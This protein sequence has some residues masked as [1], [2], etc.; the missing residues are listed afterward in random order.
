MPVLADIVARKRQDVAAR[1]A[2]TPLAVLEKQA[3]PTTRRLADALRRPGLRFIL[4]CKKASPS[5]GLIRPDFDVKKIAETYRGFADAVSV[6]T[7][8]PYF[9]GSFADLETVRA[10]LSQPILCKDFVV[11]PYQVFEAR[12][13]GADAVLLMLSVLDDA[14]YRRCAEAARALSMDVLTEV[15]DD[16]ELNRAL[17]LDARIVG[18]NNRDLKT[19]KINLSTTRHLAPKI[20]RDRVIVSESGIKSRADIDAMS[21]FVDAF[22]VGS[23]LMKDARLDSAVR[24][25]IFG[26][27]KIC[28]LT[29]PDAARIAYEAGASWGGLIFAPES[30]RCVS[31][32]SAR[33]IAEAS[34]LPMVGVFV[35][36]APEKI[37]RLTHELRLTAVQLHGEETPAYIRTLRNELPTGCEIWKAVRVGEAMPPVEAL[38]EEMG[39]DR[40]LL[41]TYN[42][43]SRGGTGGRFDWALLERLPESLRSRVIIAG[44]VT[45]G[46]VREAHGFG[47][48]AIDVNSGIE[49]APGQKDPA[50][51]QRLFSRLR[52]SL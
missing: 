31:E 10:T 21:G 4:E 23:R 5:E 52:E 45:P 42:S 26:R 20:P 15:H 22:L 14:M 17:A 1:M 12:V 6:L 43:S 9:Q 46:N 16:E 50:A 47:S 27:V 19:M 39:I 18:I 7:D 30:P 32:T 49:S 36:D 24:A 8:T 33:E 28:G 11:E 13:H 37:A 3:E 35:N 29:T 40:L 2:K 38:L 41:D 34:P 25:L 48:Y 51:L 44:G